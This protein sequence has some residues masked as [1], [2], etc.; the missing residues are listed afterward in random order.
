RAGADPDDAVL[1]QAAVDVDADFARQRKRSDGA[2][3]ET[4]HLAHAV[5]AGDLGAAAAG[6]GGDLLPVGSAIPGDEHDDRPLV[7]VKDERL[8]DLPERATDGL[9]RVLGG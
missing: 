1:E 5:R 9:C 2:R 8:D 3:L 6:L 4:G 7:A